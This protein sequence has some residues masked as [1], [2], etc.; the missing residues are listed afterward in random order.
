MNKNDELL[1]KYNDLL[2]RQ[3]ELLAEQHALQKA[4]GD[5]YSKTVQ[6]GNEI[7]EAEARLGFVTDIVEMAKQNAI[8]ELLG[9]RLIIDFVDVNKVSYTLRKR[10]SNTNQSEKGGQTK[11]Q[12]YY[13]D[14]DGNKIGPYDSAK[15]IIEALGLAADFETY[16]ENPTRGSGP[17]MFL[18]RFRKIRIDTEVVS[19]RPESAE[20]ESI[21]ENS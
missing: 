20:K 9:W 17:M 15:E 11:K 12:Y 10:P 21:S 3:N 18:K 6:K 2:A 14:D 7:I 5:R 13:Y 19:T 16:Q 1:A 4:L 8:E